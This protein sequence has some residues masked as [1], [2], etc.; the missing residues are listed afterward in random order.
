MLLLVQTS[1]A[2][3]DG[4]YACCASTV[5]LLRAYSASATDHFYTTNAAERATA[6]SQLGYIRKNL[7][8]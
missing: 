1:S 5:T 6:I 2:A 8:G 7:P 3:A 4:D